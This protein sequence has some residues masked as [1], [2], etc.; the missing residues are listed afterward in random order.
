MKQNVTDCKVHAN[1]KL[2]VYENSSKQRQSTQYN[3]RSI[4]EATFTG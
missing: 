1:M 2:K 3:C 4:W